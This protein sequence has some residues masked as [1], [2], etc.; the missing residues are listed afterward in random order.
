MAVKTPILRAPASNASNYGVGGN[1]RILGFSE[2]PRIGAVSALVQQYQ[3]LAVKTPILR[4]PA[5]NTSNLSR[6]FTSVPTQTNVSRLLPE[7]HAVILIDTCSYGRKSFHEPGSRTVGKLLKGDI[8]LILDE[9]DKYGRVVK[10][11]GPVGNSKFSAGWVREMCIST[12]IVDP[13]PAGF[14]YSLTDLDVGK[15]GDLYRVIDSNESPGTW[16]VRHVDTGVRLSEE[17]WFFRT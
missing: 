9:S 14:A 15:A 5:S 8:V 3:R 12:T 11:K 17:K 4:A 6:P 2:S 1:E 7:D 13:A 16:R 10:V